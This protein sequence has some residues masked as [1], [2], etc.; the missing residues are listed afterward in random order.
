MNHVY[1]R[2][3]NS[4]T[5]S[6]KILVSLK[7]KKDKNLNINTRDIVVAIDAGHGGKYP[8][9]VGPNNILEK[10][11]TLLIAKELERTLRDTYG[12][13]TSYDKSGDETIGLNDR[14]QNATKDRS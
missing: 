1:W 14:Y 5:N 8:G 6:E 10:D 2:K 9:A 3:A 7:L 12:Y 11:V 4:R 13:Q